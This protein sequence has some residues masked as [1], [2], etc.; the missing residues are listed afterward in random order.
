MVIDGG[1]SATPHSYLGGEIIDLD[2]LFPML[3]R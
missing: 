3:G 2:E 1:Q